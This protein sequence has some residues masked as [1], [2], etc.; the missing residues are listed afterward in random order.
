MCFRPLIFS[1]TLH[2]R[3]RLNG[4]V[5]NQLT[6]GLLSF[7]DSSP[8]AFGGYNRCLLAVRLQCLD[9][10]DLQLSLKVF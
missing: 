4:F 5:D 8:I 6:F 1:M 9:V 10:W 2:S 3:V 7:G